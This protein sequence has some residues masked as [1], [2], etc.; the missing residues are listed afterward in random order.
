MI[1]WSIASAL[2][3]VSGGIGLLLIRIIL[4]AG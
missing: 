4:G 3:P 2:T 1:V